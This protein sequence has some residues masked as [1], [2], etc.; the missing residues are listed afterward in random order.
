MTMQDQNQDKKSLVT[1]ASY[2][3][4]FEAHLAQNRLADEGI[5]A[6]VADEHLVYIS[7]VYSNPLRI[8]LLVASNNVERAMAVLSEI[9]SKALPSPT[10]DDTLFG[11]KKCPKCGSAEMFCGP[12]WQGTI[13]TSLL[14][15]G[16]PIPVPR[17]SWVCPDCGYCEKK[18]P[19]LFGIKSLLIL[20]FLVAIAFGIYVFAFPG[21]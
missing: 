18:H 4:A 19:L 11:A 21:L 10:Q 8:K 15:L 13:F 6:F 16:F 14:L 3:Q 17:R 5:Q 2:S 1:I 12:F 9:Q 7:R 20:A